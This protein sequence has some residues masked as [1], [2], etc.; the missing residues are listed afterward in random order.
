MGS[1]TIEP[2]HQQKFL[3]GQCK[4]SVLQV[5]VTTALENASAQLKPMSAPDWLTNIIGTN[6]RPQ[7]AKK[8]IADDWNEGKHGSATAPGCTHGT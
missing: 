7:Q 8:D 4:E 6:P 5:C 2:T 3:R 1:L